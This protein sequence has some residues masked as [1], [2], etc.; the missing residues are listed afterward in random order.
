MNINLLRLTALAIGLS[1]SC[2]T[3]AQRVIF[4]NGVKLNSIQIS[5]LEQFACTGVPDGSYWIDMNS[6]AWGYAGSPVRVGY[7]GDACQQ[8]QR[9]KSLSERGLLYSPGEILNGR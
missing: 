9:R 5:Q 6:G 1:T 8:S 7:V 4:V 3:F 2:A